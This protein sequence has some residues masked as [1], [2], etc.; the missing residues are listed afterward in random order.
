[1]GHL[2]YPGRERVGVFVGPGALVDW[3]RTPTE[4]TMENK[5]HKQYRTSNSSELS[6]RTS[7]GITRPSFDSGSIR[8]RTAAV[9]C[10]T[11]V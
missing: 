10:I 8:L 3:G 7:E 11:G 9:S 5:G 1:M 4:G 2:D 6:D